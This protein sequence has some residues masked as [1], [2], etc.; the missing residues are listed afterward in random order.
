MKI[1]KF[2]AIAGKL[3]I[4]AIPTFAGLAA[5]AF[6]SIAAIWNCGRELR[7][8]RA[9]ASFGL[10]VNNR[11]PHVATQVFPPARTARL[12]R[13]RPDVGL[14]GAEARSPSKRRLCKETN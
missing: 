8:P 4:S 3:V 5:S 12:S 10:E 9:L 14:P 13:P 7:L 1:M 11:S 2:P 6:A